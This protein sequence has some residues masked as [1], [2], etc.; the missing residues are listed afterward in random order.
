MIKKI[1]ICVCIIILC[2]LAYN[3]F[4]KND[5]VVDKTQNANVYE[6]ATEWKMTMYGVPEGDNM[7][8][9][10]IKSDVGGLA[11][12]DGGY[13][14]SVQDCEALLKEIAANSNVVDDWIITHFDTDHCGA[15]LKITGEH[16]EIVI[17]NIYIQ[18]IPDREILVKKGVEERSLGAIDTY[19]SRDYKNVNV[20]HAGD[21]F[22]IIGLKMKV[23]SSY[24]KWMDE[25]TNNLLNNGSMIFKLSGKE[26]SALFCA[27]AQSVEIYNYLVE[28]YE[29]D[30]DSDILQVGH[31]GNTSFPKEFFEKVS[32]EEA[33]F[34]ASNWI[35]YNERNI[36]W[37][38]IEE[39][40]QYCEEVGAKLIHLEAEPAVFTIR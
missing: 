1:F 37:F 24:D 8:S 3:F 11:I 20:V 13:D 14:V 29:A 7:M 9:F 21:E 10:T 39:V 12:I 4:N 19:L 18:E 31:H 23:L 6:N 2:L 25:K 38:T 34:P 33:V 36:E 16:P 32:P 28:N 27:D 22:N 40:K 35:Y 17:N 30:L 26:K 5:D 15:F